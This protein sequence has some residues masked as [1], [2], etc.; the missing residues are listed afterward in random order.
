MSPSFVIRVSHI[1]PAEACPANRHEAAGSRTHP[2]GRATA[3]LGVEW[4]CLRTQAK[5]EHIAAAHLR[6]DAGIE[7]YLPRIRFRRSTRKG[8]AWFTEALFPSYLFAR[9]N[10]ATCCRRVHHSPG[11]REVVHFAGS[12]PTIPD[13]VIVELK[14]ALPGREVA[15]VLTEAQPG[16]AVEISGGLFHGL[17]AVVTW[18]MPARQRVAVLLEFLG[19]QTS[20]ELA[21][22]AV[23]PDRDWRRDVLVSQVGWQGGRGEE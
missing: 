21:G 16:D 8:P 1:R 7:V 23:I 20:V 17:R 3:S 4:F 18:V 15:V 6:R 9:F 12:W 11:V 10:L 5:H 2:C 13:E 19:R 14:R 22:S